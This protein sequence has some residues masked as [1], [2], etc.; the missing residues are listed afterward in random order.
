MNNIYPLDIWYVIFQHCDLLSQLKLIAVCYSF[1]HSLS[2][3]DMSILPD[4]NIYK[5]ELTKSVLKQK[6][7]SKI[8]G[9]DIRNT[10]VDDISFFDKY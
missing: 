10:N 5:Y 1:Y 6:K 4:P 2:I 8:I 7:F 9:L 3:L